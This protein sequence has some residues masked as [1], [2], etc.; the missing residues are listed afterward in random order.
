MEAVSRRYQQATYQHD[1]YIRFALARHIA[2]GGQYLSTEAGRSCRPLCAVHRT[3]LHSARSCWN[4]H[5]PVT[6]SGT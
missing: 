6:V 1:D 2:L 4:G 5:Y 3:Y